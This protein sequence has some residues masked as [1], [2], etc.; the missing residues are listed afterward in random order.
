MVKPLSEQLADLSMRAKKAEDDL[1]AAKNE[2]HD[3]IVARREQLRA[4]T[5]QSV[6]KLKMDMK[7]ASG[8]VS[9]GFSALQAKVSADSNALKANVK[10]WKKGLDAERAENGADELEWEASM[11]IDYAISAVEQA[12]LA[13]IDAVI[14]R[15]EAIEAR[16][17]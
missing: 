11:A 2:T 10:Q 3:K 8:A 16:K 1:S 9:S 6:E 5:T 17:A 4:G 7:S 13:A 15:Q 12:K 14:G